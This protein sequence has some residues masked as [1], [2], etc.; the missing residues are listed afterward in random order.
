MDR[1]PRWVIIGEPKE[2]TEVTLLNRIL[3]SRRNR[4]WRVILLGFLLALVSAAAC[5]RSE[6][7]TAPEAADE[8]ELRQV[9]LILGWLA[10]PARGG[11]YSAL[12]EGYYEDVGLD[13][14]LVPGIDVSAVQVVAGGRADFALADADEILNARAKNIPLVSVL[15]TFQTSPRLLVFHQTDPIS[16]FDDLNGRTV[17][18]D[19]GDEWWEYIKVTENLSDVEERAFNDKAFLQQPGTVIQGYIGDVSLYEGTTG[20]QFGALFVADSGYNPYTNAVFTTEQYIADNRE[21]VQRF[22]QASVKG[23]EFYRNN[24]KATNEY[25][26]QFNPEYPTKQM[27]A[28]AEEQEKLIYGGDASS[29][30]I[31]YMTEERWTKML[32]ALRQV[33]VIEDSVS[34]NI[35]DIFTNEFLPASQG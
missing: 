34:I 22:I 12:L 17:Y 3:A 4:G 13:V 7:A 5:G 2:L 26:Q 8:K 14:R 28:T 1:A 24:F 23:W 10:E 16:T 9:T 19:L 21:I 6:E 30:G 20:K 32:D 15:G 33:G 18:L 31:G 29:R 27:D 11:F 25:M 35:N